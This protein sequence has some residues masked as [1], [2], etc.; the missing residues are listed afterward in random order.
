MS[1]ILLFLI[2]TYQLT[3]SYFLGRQCRFQPTCSVYMQQAITQHGAVRGLQLGIRR[4]CKCHPWGAA[5]FD[6]VPEICQAS[7]QQRT[8]R[9][10]P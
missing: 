9:K 4:L 1:S 3:L 2:R 10:A 6:P 7:T 5:G 8:Q